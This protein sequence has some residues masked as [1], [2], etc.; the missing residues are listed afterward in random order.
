[1]SAMNKSPEINELAKALAQFQACCPPVQMDSNVTVTPERGRS[2]S[3]KYASLET[4]VATV[5]PC[6]K[7]AGLSFSQLL[8]ADG[9]VI[10]LLLHESG[11]WLE[12]RLKIGGGGRP[13]EV[14]SAISY[15]KRYALSALL[16]VVAEEDD[17]A[18]IAQ[19]NAVQ[20]NPK[21][22]QQPAPD[23][24]EW[25]MLIDEVRDVDGANDL[26]SRIRKQFPT[27][28]EGKPIKGALNR[29][30]ATLRLRFSEKENAFI[31]AAA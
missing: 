14:G 31:H 26:L 16:G 9:T 28:D 1:M 10:T 4:I 18:N 19:G 6:L 20:K 8:E 11:Q 5:R 27:P 23:L 29:K 22:A 30:C 24:G 13:Q 12:S 15:A 2:Y 7:E 3:F 17:D 25:G 21:P